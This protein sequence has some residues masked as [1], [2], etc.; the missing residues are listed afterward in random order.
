MF[1]SWHLV[2][3]DP[4]EGHSCF[5]WAEATWAVSL[6]DFNIY[7]YICVCVNNLLSNFDRKW[8]FIF[9]EKFWSGKELLKL[10]LH[11]F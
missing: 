5:D 10:K 9:V 4:E 8:A 11:S 6:K 7:V 2:G 1:M 3:R